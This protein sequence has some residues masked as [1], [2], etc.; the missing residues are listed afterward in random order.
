MGTLK[1]HVSENFGK[2]L[3]KVLLLIIY[4]KTEVHYDLHISISSKVQKD[5]SQ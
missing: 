5:K 4:I 1:E 2:L 3:G